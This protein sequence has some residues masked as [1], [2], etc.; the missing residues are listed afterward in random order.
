[1]FRT[2]LT[3]TSLIGLTVTSLFASTAL[4]GAGSE[5]QTAY[6]GARILNY[7]TEVSG[8]YEQVGIYGDDADDVNRYASWQGDTLV[9]GA[10]SDEGNTV[11]GIAEFFWFESSVP[12]SADLYL[13][14]LK[15]RSSPLIG[16]GWQLSQEDG[17][18]DGWG[19][20]PASQSVFAEMAG[21]G[22]NG[23]I[24][25]SYSL[26]YQNYG[27][28][29]KQVNQISQ[30]YSAGVDLTATGSVGGGLGAN[31]GAK[32]DIPLTEGVFLKT[33]VDSNTSIDGK[34]Q[35]KGYFQKQYSVTSNYTV[36]VY[37]W[38]MAVTGGAVNDNDNKMMW[39]LFVTEDNEKEDDSAYHEYFLA[40]QV[41]QG[42][43]GHIQQLSIAGAFENDWW[44]GFGESKDESDVIVADITFE[45]P[46]EI[47]C[48]WNDPTPTAEETGCPSVGV[49]A[50]VEV[51]CNEGKW[52]C[53]LPQNYEAGS[54]FS[55]DG[56]DNDCDGDVDEDVFQY[57]WDACGEGVSVCGNGLWSECSTSP[58]VEKCDGF[59]NNCDG[60]ID[61]SLSKSCVTEHGGVGSQE[62]VFGSW[63]SCLLEEDKVETCNGLDDN[64]NGQV[65]EALEVDCETSCGMGT[66]TC[67]SGSWSTCTAPLPSAEICDG[68]DNDCDGAVDDQLFQPCSNAVG[69]P[70]EETCISG[71]WMFCDAPEVIMPGS[72]TTGTDAAA[73]IVVTAPGSGCT[74][75][76]SSPVSTFLL[77][78]AGLSGLVIRRR[79][80]A[81]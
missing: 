14:L 20:N 21:D 73:P 75:G 23:A 80:A 56:L 53:V 76:G 2:H 66:Q 77:I 25:F 54:E 27:Y 71:K 10:T 9:F 50:N 43:T 7:G 65:D 31:A 69:Q 64:F 34:I 46:S 13:V 17:F 11:D 22:A 42:K 60:L 3:L 45:P 40:V 79:S 5:S 16:D 18:W 35:S 61:E 57:C 24:N 78:L 29:V 62:C 67:L 36:T 81:L 68:I 32:F 6:Q 41:P 30:G 44:I 12:K 52:A 74:G 15:V 48:Y 8:G 1:M 26:P 70:G 4:A 58:D 38:Q 28:D 59:D 39:D 51:V 19:A 55:C 37:N 47:E 49:C 33:A 72:E 63:T